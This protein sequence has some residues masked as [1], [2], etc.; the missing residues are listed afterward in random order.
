M[1][2]QEF[3]TVSSG[4]RSSFTFVKLSDIKNGHILL[5]VRPLK[6]YQQ[7]VDLGT[8]SS[9]VFFFFFFSPFFSS[10]HLL[11]SLFFFTFPRIN[12]R[13]SRPGPHTYSRLFSPPLPA[14]V[15]ALHFYREKMSAL[16][17]PSSTRVELCLP[18][19][20]ALRG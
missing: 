6:A 12:S 18:T 2:S 9:P 16:R 20:G 8:L 15:R 14:T 4:F 13:N 3:A 10:S 17:L 5:T 7:T 11:S 19:L 1:N